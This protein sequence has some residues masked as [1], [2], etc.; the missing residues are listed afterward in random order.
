[1]TAWMLAAALTFA[2]TADGATAL[3]EGL[4]LDRPVDDA[5]ATLSFDWLELEPMVIAADRPL[6]QPVTIRVAAKGG[7]DRVVLEL[8]G[9]NDRIVLHD[10][11]TAPDAAAGDGVYAAHVPVE[12]ILARDV[13]ERHGRPLLGRV[14]PMLGGVLE[15]VSL[16][17]QADV[18]AASDLRTAVRVSSGKP[19]FQYTSHVVNL[20]DDAF[21]ARYD[22]PGLLGRALPAVGDHYDF[23]DV[24]MAPRRYVANRFHFG[25]RNRVQGIGLPVLDGGRSYGSPA[26]LLGV[27][28]FPT[29][30]YYDPAGDGYAHEVGHQ[31]VN[32]LG[33][34]LHSTGS[35]WPISPLAHAVM[36]WSGDGGQGQLLG[37]RLTRENG[38]VR[39]QLE[40]NAITFNAW[41]LYL[42]GLVPA[43]EVP[44]T[45]RFTD[46]GAALAR[47][48]QPNWCNGE[49]ALATTD[50]TVDTI[51]NAHGPR[52][53]DVAGSQRAFRVLTLVVS[54]GRLLDASE[55]AYVTM[56]ARRHDAREPIGYAT[57]YATGLGA[58]FAVATGLRATT[59]A[60]LVPMAT[61]PAR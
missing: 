14:R 28:A 47:V 30:S 57:G 22:Y 52:I 59:D 44:P 55:L 56:L 21:Y 20:R 34:T 40:P 15:P 17:V 32:F 36:G 2:S 43:A 61:K 39:A 11:G 45:F 5:K 6:D 3:P 51:L 54:Q 41:E 10:D 38:V 37:C 58:N 12:E 16:L 23:V 8:A 29:F 4:A 33:A 7:P 53:P 1:M 46:Q 26:R 35:H 48:N 42:M 60:R 18:A 49:I 31:W 25:V 9:S 27:S 24:L 13:P 50:L 19:W